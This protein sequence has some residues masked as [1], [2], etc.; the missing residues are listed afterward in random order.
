[1]DPRIR[2]RIHTKMSWIRNTASKMSLRG[3][4]TVEIMGSSN[5]FFVLLMEGTGSGSRSLRPIKKKDP[6]DPEDCSLCA[7]TWRDPWRWWRWRGRGDTQMPAGCTRKTSPPSYCPSFYAKG[8]VAWDYLFQCFGDPHWFLVGL[9]PDPWELK[10]TNKK[11]KNFHVLKCWMFS[12][13]MIYFSV[14]GSAL[15][16][17]GWIRIQESKKKPKKKEKNKKF[18]VL[19]CWMFSFEGWR[20]LL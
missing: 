13:E 9:D 2:I 12:F 20:L 4:K 14:L 5:N 15:I 16:W 1:M 11:R 8:T 3:H 19:K 6:T 17:S 10:G 7:C 18:H